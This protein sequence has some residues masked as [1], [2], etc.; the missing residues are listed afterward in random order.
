MTTVVNRGIESKAYDPMERMEVGITI[1]NSPLPCSML[2]EMTD[3]VVGMTMLASDEQEEKALVP[4]LVIAVGM[5]M[6]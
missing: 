6:Y 1:E 4:I 2:S 5:Y 3:T